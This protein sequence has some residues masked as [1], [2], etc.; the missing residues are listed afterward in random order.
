MSRSQDLAEKLSHH[1]FGLERHPT[2]P[3]S[4]VFQPARLS[5]IPAAPSLEGTGSPQPLSQ[6]GSPLIRAGRSPDFEPEDADGPQQQAARW[7]CWG[8]V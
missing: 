1:S 6:Q 4:G 2:R 5:G 3:G 8:A 7:E